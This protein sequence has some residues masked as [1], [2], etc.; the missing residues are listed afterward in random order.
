MLRCSFSPAPGAKP[1]TTCVLE[2]FETVCW[3][4]RPRPEMLPCSFGALP[5][6]NPSKSSISSKFRNCLLAY[7]AQAWN[8][9]LQLQPLA[10]SRMFRNCLL[11][12]STQAW[13]CSGANLSKSCTLLLPGLQRLPRALPGANPSKS[14][15]SS[16]FRNC[17]LAHSAQ[18]WNASLYFF[19]AWNASSALCQVQILPNPLSLYVF[20]VSKL[21]FL[22]TET[23]RLIHWQLR[24]ERLRTQHWCLPK[25]STHIFHARTGLGALSHVEK[26][27]ITCFQRLAALASQK[28]TFSTNSIPIFLAYRKLTGWPMWLTRLYVSWLAFKYR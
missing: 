1:C 15:I 25:W 11:A 18:A 16:K 14:S 26:T 4:I 7:S 19:R 8:A 23:S 28:F 6:A 12:Y 10:C 20:E 3:P 9:S 24:N 22:D 17:L 21:P 5:G 2:G 27:K 13:N